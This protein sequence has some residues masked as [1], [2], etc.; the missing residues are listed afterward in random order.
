MT[1]AVRVHAYGGPEV[2][3]VENV[4]VGA[5]GPGEVRMR[6][7]AIGLNFIDVYCRTG[8]YPQPSLPFIPGTEGAGVVAALGAGVTDLKEGDRVAYASPIGG[9]SEE[10]LIPADKLVK[11]PA[12][13]SDETAAAMMLQGMTV[14]YLLDRTFK[15]GPGTVLLFHAAAGGVGLIACQWARERGATFIGTVGSDEKAALAK[16][17]GAAHV[18]N[19]KT[20]NFVER[21]RAITGGKLCDV[22]YDFIG[23]DTFPASLDCIK[24]R[25]MFVSFGNAS[26]PVAAFNLGLLSQKG[27]LYATRPTLG[28][29]TATRADLE[30][31]AG[32]LFDMVGR[33]K[34]KINVNQRFPLSKVADAHR[35]LEG[36]KTTGSTI[37]LPG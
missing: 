8:L 19:L 7:T 4:D 33:G 37:L 1:R 25:G 23:R 16:A 15:I 5:P 18:I 6:Q 22:V 2:L 20:E 11:I 36:R 32:M 29:Y 28:S 21:V 26:G 3:S 35:A 31:S 10:R 9:Y 14:E 13:V 12:G 24:P 27:S 17:H 34:V 30:A